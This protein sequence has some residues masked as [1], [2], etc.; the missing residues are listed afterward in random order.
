[1]SIVKKA[2]IVVIA[3]PLCFIL[4]V[5]SMIG[6]IVATVANSDQLN[7]STAS[8]TLPYTEEV[9]RWR[10]AVLEACTNYGLDPQYVEL[11]LA[12]MMQESGGTGLDPMQA[13]ESGY[14][15]LYPNE[16]GGIQDPQY[17]IE[18]GVQVLRDVLTA[19]GVTGNQDFEHIPLALQSYNYGGGYLTWAV[20]N[21][22]GYSAQNAVEFSE[23]MKQ[24]LGWDV[25]GDPD[26]VPHVLQYYINYT[27]TAENNYIMPVLGEYTIGRTFEE[28]QGIELI[29][30]AGTEVVVMSHC[31]I[32]EMGS[33]EED[34]LW[35]SAGDDYGFEVKYCHLQ[36][37]TDVVGSGNILAQGQVIGHVGQSGNASQ[38][39]LLLKIYDLYDP[40]DPADY[41]PLNTNT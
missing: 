35:V 24:E 3:I 4:I 32:L 9:L 13:S 14:N 28:C 1:M 38:P 16:S 23:M 29:A 31:T 17:S 6:G 33:N 2:I 8:E 15:T 40:V 5:L 19:A 26:Y 12:V 30:P 27:D 25:Y 41:L 20:E 34:G 39:M 7:T 21:Y 10:P 36:D 37:Y 11:V 18:C 22:G